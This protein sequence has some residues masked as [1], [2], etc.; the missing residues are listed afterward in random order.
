VKISEA[1]LMEGM[2]WGGAARFESRHRPGAIA[3]LMVR[4]ADLERVLEELKT[5]RSRSWHVS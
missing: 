3:Q 1:E 2:F 4:R 5:E